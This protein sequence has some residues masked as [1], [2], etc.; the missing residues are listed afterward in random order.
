M[1]PLLGGASRKPPSKALPCQ[2]PAGF[3]P[4]NPKW[5]GPHQKPHC[6][7]DKIASKANPNPE[8]S[9]A[10][11][12]RKPGSEI[13]RDTSATGQ[14]LP[15]RPPPVPSHFKLQR[16]HPLGVLSSTSS[17][18]MLAASH[19]TALRPVILGDL[20]QLRPQGEEKK[21]DKSPLG[22][23]RAGQEHPWPGRGCSTRCLMHQRG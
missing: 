23:F 12:C 15:R 1:N 21:L 18:G 10:P 9:P 7:R 2:S 11:S 4:F 13:S 19:P 14:N 22:G 5:S 6:P 16:L 20:Q 8:P 17:P 3:S